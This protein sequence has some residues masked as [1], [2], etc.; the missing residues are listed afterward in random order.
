MRTPLL[1]DLERVVEFYR[2]L[3]DTKDHLTREELEHA[4]YK[5]CGTIMSI[6]SQQ[7]SIRKRSFAFASDKAEITAV[8]SLFREGNLILIS[9]KLI[10]GIYSSLP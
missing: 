3:W 9:S 2:Q 1:Y 6:R 10:S 4:P 5:P 7:Y 8:L